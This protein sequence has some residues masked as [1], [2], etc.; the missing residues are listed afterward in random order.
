MLLH[1]QNWFP[2][3]RK[4]I[5]FDTDPVC[6]TESSEEALRVTVDSSGGH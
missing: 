1:P 3:E 4:Y 6:Q 5:I 2:V